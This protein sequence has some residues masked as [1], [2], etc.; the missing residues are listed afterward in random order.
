M[1]PVRLLCDCMNAQWRPI[2]SIDLRSMGLPPDAFKRQTYRECP[3][4]Y[5]GYRAVDWLDSE[6]LLVAFNTSP[7]CA[8]HEGL[9]PGSLRLVTF[10]FEGV[11]LHSTDVPYDAGDGIG[12]RVIF[13]DGIWVGPQKTIIVEIPSPHFRELPDS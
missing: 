3:Y 10:D 9:V 12:V 2:V 8:K 7:D 5:L 4:G 13:H 6:R 11:A 1:V